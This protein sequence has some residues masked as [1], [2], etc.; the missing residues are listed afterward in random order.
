MP[1]ITQ[2]GTA[3]TIQGSEPLPIVQAGET[4]KVSAQSLVT[5]PIF[6]IDLSSANYPITQYGIYYITVGSTGGSPYEIELP[7]PTTVP[8]MELLFFNYDQTN[9]ALIESTYQ[10]L[11]EASTN[12][13]DKVT[14]INAAQ[15]TLLI[16]ING[17]WSALDYK[18]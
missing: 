11:I 9:F 8:G 1:K 2:L 17:Y 4:K 12:P 5:K 18:R 7:D 6:E 10:P 15:A 3:T 13:A 14:R 16:A